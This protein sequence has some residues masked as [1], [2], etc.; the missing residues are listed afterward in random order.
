WLNIRQDIAHLHETGAIANYDLGVAVDNSLL[1]SYAEATAAAGWG[2]PLSA[3]GVTQYMPGVGGR[4]DIGITTQS[5]TVWLMTQDIRAATHALGQAE[6]ASAVPWNMWDGANGRWL[7]TEDYPKLWTDGRGGTGT[8]GDASSGGLTQQGDEISGWTPESAHQPD[9]SFVPYILTGERW[10]LD[11]LQAQAAWNVVSQWAD[12]RGEDGNLLVQNNQV[13]GSAWALRQID[14]AAWA[15]PDG[16][17]E[18]AYFSKVSDAN[19]SWIVQQIPTWTAEQGEAHGWLPGEYGTAG[20]LPPWQQDYFAST[21]IAAARHGNEDALTYLEWAS[22]FLV[23]RFQHAADGFAE[24][25]G[26]AYLLAISDPATGRIFNTWSEIGATTASYNWSN[27]DGWSHSEGDYVQLALATLSGIAELTGSQAAVDAYH[28]LLA[29]N[30]P[31]TTGHDFSRDP[32]FAI[33]A[34]GEDN[35]PVFQIPAPSVPHDTAPPAHTAP[36]AAPDSNHGSAPV[37]TA[38]E[39]PAAGHPAGGVP[40][41][42]VLGGEAWEGNPLAVVLVDGVEVFRGEVT[43]SHAH[44]GAEIALGHV[45][46]GADHEVVVQFLN[47][48]WGGSEDTDR[49]LYV[50]DIRI[51]GIS[52]GSTAALLDSNSDASFSITAPAVQPPA[53]PAPVQQPGEVPLSIVLGGEAWEGNPLAVVLVDGVEVFRGEVTASH[54]RGGAE[55]ALGHVAA[56]ADHEVVVQFLNDA[57]GGSEDT[58]RNLY[59]EDIRINGVSTGSTA[60]LLDSNNDASFS[61]TVP[62]AQPPAAPAPVEQAPVP[63]PAGEVPLSIVLGGEAWE[64]NPLAVVLVDGVEVFRGEVTASHARGGA[65]IALGHVAAGAEHEVVVQFLNDAWGGSE[66]TD[67]N[68]YVEDIRING[69][70]TGSTAA[71]LDS[72]NDASFSITVPAAPAPV[73]PLAGEV[74]LSIVLGGEAWE[75]NP[76][77]VVL[78]NG[79]EV[80]RGEVTASHAHG[81]AE[82]ALGSFA[83]GGAHEVVVQFL[84]DAW[85]GSSDTDRNLYVE[86]IRINGVSTGNTA[87]LLD[88]NCDAQFS[89]AVPAAQALVVAQPVA[90]DA[91]LSIVLGGEAWEGNPEAV[92]LVD[93]AEAFRGE[94]TASH[95][96]GG[97][98]I[99]LGSFA[100]GSAHEVVVQFLNDAWGGSSDTDRNLYVED[101]RIN[102]VSTGSTADLLANGDVDFWVSTMPIDSTPS[103]DAASFGMIFF[104]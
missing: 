23:G 56:G 42:I 14:E 66:D 55:I 51:N 13:R 52:T 81:G 77:A 59:V 89:I 67:R 19:W 97:A 86:D 37:E 21:A 26:A 62:A 48:A 68:L 63:Q 27:G 87:D 2:E 84:N 34:P 36:D 100:A 80:F 91:A 6:T 31:F 99:S 83:A 4:A 65:E 104:G 28:A 90:T 61:I 98:E 76:L 50:E 8:P 93:G 72:N 70:S 38:P 79:V 73:Q 3:N 88:G 64:G 74:P 32:T 18:Q 5:N 60:A 58:D 43:A 49:N 95:A 30:P 20:A 39:A 75:G 102:G 12:M 45:A 15:S 82:I 35:T 7:N 96:N 44:G 10:M 24:H 25:D 9:L 47:D 94:V 53:A 78:V 101:I 54:A 103:H 33:V 69:V 57:W 1:Q 92:V 40:L 71:L 22:N 11:N 29:D 85:G 41:S 16:S 46:A 17:A